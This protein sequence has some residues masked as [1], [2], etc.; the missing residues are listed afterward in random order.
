MSIQ[1]TLETALSSYLAPAA[2]K[3]VAEVQAKAVHSALAAFL[4]GET[5]GH[6]KNGNG[7]TNGHAA[8]R[9]RKAAAPAEVAA[10]AGAATASDPSKEVMKLKKLLFWAQKRAEQGG[11]AKP[12]DAELIA[13]AD[14]IANLST[15]DFVAKGLTA[16]TFLRKAKSKTKAAAAKK[17]QPAKRGR[18]KAAEVSPE[19]PV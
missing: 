12:D 1:T 15:A 18:R 2:A 10:P 5:N 14:E 6:H 13:R 9:G 8:K 16:E 11:A 17:G 3:Q 7:H 4:G 19:L